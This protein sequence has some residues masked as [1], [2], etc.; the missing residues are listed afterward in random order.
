ME[1]PYMC[2]VCGKRFS[3]SDNLAQH[4][5]T[6]DRNKSIRGNSVQ[7]SSTSRSQGSKKSLT[8]KP[9]INTST[10][11]SSS[12]R[13]ASTNGFLSKSINK[14]FPG[15]QRNLALIGG[16]GNSH[17]N[18]DIS[19]TRSIYRENT[20]TSISTR[21]SSLPLP[22][23]TNRGRILRRNAHRHHQQQQQERRQPY[24]H[25]SRLNHDN[26]EA[27][28]IY[29]SDWEQHH[30]SIEYLKVEPEQML[31]PEL[32]ISTA[33]SSSTSSCNT[34]PTCTR[35][36]TIKI[37]DVEP[38]YDLQQQQQQTEDTAMMMVEEFLPQ[39]H[40]YC[41]EDESASDWQRR[42]DWN[43]YSSPGS[44]HYD[45]TEDL[46][47]ESYN[48]EH[49]ENLASF[50]NYYYLNQPSP[51][52]NQYDIVSNASSCLASPT[53]VPSFLIETTATTSTSNSAATTVVNSPILRTT[54]TDF[55][56]THYYSNESPTITPS[57]ALL[58]RH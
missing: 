9:N 46:I 51:Q 53:M 48:N 23:V 12:G 56:P 57:D 20:T 49:Q 14:S 37:E 19:Y 22:I 17:S 6:H 44:V 18:N 4:K 45:N 8:N 41:W 16:S 5:K 7:P 10:K 36:P 35:L 28:V 15:R 25:H 40:Q 29:E 38:F 50:A 24:Q 32:S 33:S 21:R 30:T 55:H 47:M 43:Q 26:V 27:A 54:T 39:Q 3:R 52:Y 1:R 11:T 13:K 58:Q 42:V 31:Q 2:D 34:S